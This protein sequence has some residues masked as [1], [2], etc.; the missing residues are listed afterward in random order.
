M[1]HLKREVCH[2]FVNFGDATSGFFFHAIE[3]VQKVGAVQMDAKRARCASGFHGGGNET[4]HVAE[5]EGA[6]GAVG[7]G[8]FGGDDVLSHCFITFHSMALTCS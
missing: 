8:E 3:D 5:G 4:A 6:R 7:V 2:G 1:T